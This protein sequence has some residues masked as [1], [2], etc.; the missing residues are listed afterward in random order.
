MRKK[1]IGDELNGLRVRTNKIGLCI[2]LHCVEL[3]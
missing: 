1:C 2:A 3:V